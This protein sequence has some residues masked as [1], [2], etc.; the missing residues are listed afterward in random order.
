MSVYMTFENR[1]NDSV[2]L[3]MGPSIAWGG[4]GGLTGKGAQGNFLG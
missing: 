2:V 4:D 1:Q 3:G